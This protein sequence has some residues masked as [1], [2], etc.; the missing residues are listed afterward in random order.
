[1][2][3]GKYLLILKRH[4]DFSRCCVFATNMSNDFDFVPKTVSFI[5]RVLNIRML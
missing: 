2:H 1:M 5:V 4:V 3:K